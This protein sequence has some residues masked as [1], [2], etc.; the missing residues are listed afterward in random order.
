L[1]HFGPTALLSPLL[2]EQLIGGVGSGAS[3]GRDHRRVVSIVNEV[4]LWPSRSLTAFT[5]TPAGN[6]TCMS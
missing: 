6:A 4:L 2:A 5:C 3:H 1:D